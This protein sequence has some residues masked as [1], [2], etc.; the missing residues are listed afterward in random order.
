M[1]FSRKN[2]LVYLTEDKRK[3]DC[4]QWIQKINK[5]CATSDLVIVYPSDITQELQGQL[6]QAA[7]YFTDEKSKNVLLY[8]QELARGGLGESLQFNLVGSLITPIVIYILANISGG[9]LS[10]FGRDLYEKFLKNI[11]NQRRRE[12]KLY[13][14]S[15]ML[16][17]KLDG[18]ILQYYFLHHHTEIEKQEAYDSIIH[19]IISVSPELL[20]QD[21]ARFVWDR[22]KQ[23]WE[24]L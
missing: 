12:N 22:K 6:H 1:F 19:H 18:T 2:K 3:E 23:S 16:Q 21:L 13:F 4:I 14:G 10:E 17:I 11:F 5:L 15:A 7:S 8:K 24:V 9:F 20:K